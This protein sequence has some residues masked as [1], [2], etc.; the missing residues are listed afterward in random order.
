M[1]GWVLTMSARISQLFKCW[2]SDNWVV[3]WV[4]IKGCLRIKQEFR[5]WVL[6]TY[7]RG[8][9]WCPAYSCAQLWGQV[10]GRGERGDEEGISTVSL[11]KFLSNLTERVIH[12]KGFILLLQVMVIKRFIPNWTQNLRR[13]C[14][15][16][17]QNGEGNG[18]GHGYY[19]CHCYCY[20]SW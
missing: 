9:F 6:I 2:L 18:K 17:T 1:G 11:F 15:E 12:M 16:N 19:H 5:S 10:I 3:D 8:R 7:P 14:P 4:S 13:D 20:R